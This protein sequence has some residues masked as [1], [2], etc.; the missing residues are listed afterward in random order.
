LVSNE[1]PRHAGGYWWGWLVSAASTDALGGFRPYCQ[2][3]FDRVAVR[4][5]FRA[6]DFLCDG[7]VLASLA[8]VATAELDVVHFFL[9][10]TVV[11]FVSSH[12]ER[13]DWFWVSLR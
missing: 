7:G 2:G 3:D 5:D 13:F 8:G 12:F 10:S 1:N 9:V 4:S 11:V 6:G